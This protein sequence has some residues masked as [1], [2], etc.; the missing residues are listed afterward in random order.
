MRTKLDNIELQDKELDILRNAVA[1]AEK[2]RH[3]II[4]SPIIKNIFNIL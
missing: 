4:S 1:K 2:K 3:D